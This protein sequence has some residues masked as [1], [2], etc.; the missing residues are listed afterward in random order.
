MLD[1]NEFRKK[2]ST[3]QGRSDLG[4]DLTDGQAAAILADDA[5]ID[6]WHRKVSAPQPDMRLLV[7]PAPSSSSTTKSVEPDDHLSDL[8]A[9]LGVLW[10]GLKLRVRKV[11][12]RRWMAVLAGVVLVATVSVAGVVIAD[13]NRAQRDLALANAETARE[14]KAAKADDERAAE[15]EKERAAEKREREALALQEAPAKIADAERA[16]ASSP[17]A[18]PEALASLTTLK[19]KLASAV[20][21]KDASNAWLFTTQLPQ[22]IDGLGTLEQSQDRKYT[23][24]LKA[25]GRTLES[26]APDQ[27]LRFSAGREWCATN[28]PGWASD[29]NSDERVSTV[30][31]LRLADPYAKAAIAGYC[32]EL[33]AAKAEADAYL[34][35]GDYRVGGDGIAPGTYVTTKNRK[36]CYWERHTLNGDILA[37]DFITAAPD[38]VSVT[39][40]SGEGFSVSGCGLWRKAG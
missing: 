32:P 3:E 39:V 23:E 37:N 1:R 24:A 33:G 17:W 31:A 4:L 7:R 11:S 19:D 6:S 21:L 40:R 28:A 27:E 13:N 8:L 2:L 29:I 14:A 10:I 25:E 22:A 34:E 9:K 35:D 38:G 26:A 12:Q 18:S 36:D 30:F 16:I 15:A 20:E 5:L